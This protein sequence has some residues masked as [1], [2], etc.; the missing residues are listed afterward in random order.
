[1]KCPFSSAP[2]HSQ[3][4]MPLFCSIL[5]RPLKNLLFIEYKLLFVIK[6]NIIEIVYW[7]AIRTLQFYGEK[8]IVLKKNIGVVPLIGTIP[9]DIV[10][11]NWEE[12]TDRQTK[13]HS[14]KTFKWTILVYLYFGDLRN[15]SNDFDT[16]S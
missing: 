14:C 13:L 7:C 1:M 9:I 4:T 6:N 10:V 3:D 12:V 8:T 5:F 15:G 11:V 2:T 16:F